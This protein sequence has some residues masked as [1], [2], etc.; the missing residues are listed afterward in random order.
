MSLIDITQ[1][2]E[3]YF[4]YETCYFSYYV[5]AMTITYFNTEKRIWQEIKLRTKKDK[6]IIFLPGLILGYYTEKTT[7]N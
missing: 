3:T 5:I 7:N 6:L 1:L 4:N 2:I